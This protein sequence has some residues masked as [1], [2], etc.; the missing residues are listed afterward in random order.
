[1]LTAID[2]IVTK[3]ITINIVTIIVIMAT[4]YIVYSATV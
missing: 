3:Y 2:R 1:M 4:N